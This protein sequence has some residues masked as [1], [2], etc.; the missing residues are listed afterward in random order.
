MRKLASGQSV[1]FCAPLEVDRRIRA[2]CNL[3]TAKEVAVEHVLH[4]TMRESCDDILHNVPHWA[5]QGVDYETRR[6]DNPSNLKEAWLR[7]EARSLEELYGPSQDSQ[8]Q[9]PAY[10]IPAMKKRL[11]LLGIA[12]IADAR[13]E[14][15]SLFTSCTLSCC[16]IG[17]ELIVCD[18]LFNVGTRARSLPRG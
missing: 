5:E 3:D 12:S 18:V 6:G 4:W 2:V 8:A 14:E 9:H 15:V 1:M 13:I 11:K 7:P 16:D 10:G 17:A